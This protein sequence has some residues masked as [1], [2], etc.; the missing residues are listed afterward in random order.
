MKVRLETDGG[1]TGRGIGYVEIDGRK[2]T[3]S[4]GFR[5]SSGALSEDEERELG[6]LLERVPWGATLGDV[7]PDQITYTLTYEGRSV[8]WRGE[9]EMSGV[10]DFFGGVRRR[11][12]PPHS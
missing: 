6:S 2:V 4:D 9:Q 10:L 11:L 5:V 8:S 7:H 3:G 1:F 12:A